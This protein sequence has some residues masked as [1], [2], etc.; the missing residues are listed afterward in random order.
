MLL[1][2]L[3]YPLSVIVIPG[4]IVTAGAA[5]LRVL[6][7]FAVGGL[8]GDVFLHLLPEAWHH[9]MMNSKGGEVSMR[10]LRTKTSDT[11]SRTLPPTTT[12]VTESHD[13][14]TALRE[15]TTSS[16]LMEGNRP[17]NMKPT[18]TVSSPESHTRT[19][20]PDQATTVTDERITTTI[21]TTDLIR[22]LYIKKKKTMTI[23]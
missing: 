3:Q 15:S 12:S 8:L 9:D 5:T 2:V 6:L 17:L 14:G 4:V 10:S 1:Y 19:S 23:C 11:W 18:R 21:I 22:R 16:N 20:A 7:S 13:E